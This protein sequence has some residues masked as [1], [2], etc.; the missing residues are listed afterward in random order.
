MEPGNAYIITGG[1]EGK[2]RL[3]I[4]ANVLHNYTKP[5]LQLNG[6]ATGS[7]FLDVGCG[8]GNV[9]LMAAG[10]VG[11]TGAVTGID[12]D[13]EI[14]KL[15]EVD[16]SGKGFNHINYFAQSAYNLTY[17]NE[18]DVVYSRFLLSHLTRPG[19]VLNNMLQAAKTGGK[20]IVEDIDF[21]GH[22]CFPAS[23][24]FEQYVN[25]FTATAQKRGHNANIGP[26]LFNLFKDAGIKSINFD[27]IQ[28]AFNQGDGKRMAIITMDKIKQ[29][30][31][32]EG[33]ATT[34]TVDR[35]ISELEIFTNNMQSVISLPR[36]FRVWGVKG[37]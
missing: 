6:L 29:A 35:I 25:L 20:I 33:L 8:G 27:I 11:K 36:I 1:I 4:L 14:I 32:T 34:E 22:F 17:K 3:D 10:L 12:F 15:D 30:V 5:L 9:T 37:S 2:K 24:A 21:S 13:E 28:P 7:S 23:A 26:S 19:V 31:I 18:F 16:T